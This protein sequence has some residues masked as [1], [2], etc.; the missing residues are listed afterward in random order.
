MIV[1]STCHDCGDLLQVTE[2]RQTAHPGCRPRRTK[3]ERLADEWLAAVES[4]D[5]ATERAL[6]AQ[7]DTLDAAA[8]RLREA[9]LAYASWGWPVFPLLPG[10]KRPATRRG[11]KDATTDPDLIGTWW[12]QR[13]NY[14]IG[15]PTGVAFDV[16]DIDTPVGVGAYAEL[17]AESSAGLGPIGDVHGIVVT[18]N[19]GLHLYISP[20]G[21]GNRAGIVPGID[22]RG[23]GG[24]VVAPPSTLGERA[25]GWSW[26][27]EPSPAITAGMAAAQ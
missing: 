13:P 21:E 7:I 19:S 25:Q 20:T 27:S 12:T 23:V 14:N 18:A 8:P 10:Q 2:F 17:I 1:Y 26:I 22:Y 6:Q 16:I 3:A 9:A 11:F 15:L 4:G 5:S 24:Y